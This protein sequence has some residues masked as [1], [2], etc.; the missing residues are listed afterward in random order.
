M[1]Q[2]TRDLIFYNRGLKEGALHVLQRIQYLPLCELLKK[3]QEYIDGAEDIEL[4]L[5]AEM[6]ATSNP[7]ASQ[8]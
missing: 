1:T 5:I 3:T 7:P 6:E 4:R 2:S 8:L